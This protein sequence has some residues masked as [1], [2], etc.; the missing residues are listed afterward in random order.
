LVEVSVLVAVCVEVTAEVMVAVL[1]S[2]MVL[3]LSTTD[4]ETHTLVY[5]VGTTTVLTWVVVTRAVSV[6]LTV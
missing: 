1:V 5:V 6:S 2:E 4:V 3:V